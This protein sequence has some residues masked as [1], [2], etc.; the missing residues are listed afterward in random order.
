MTRRAICVQMASARPVAVRTGRKQSRTGLPGAAALVAV[1][2]LVMGLA[3][4]PLAQAQ[5]EFQITDFTRPG[6]IGRD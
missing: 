3:L 4:A 1:L 5:D 2:A 6:Q